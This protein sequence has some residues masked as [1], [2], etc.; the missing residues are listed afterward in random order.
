MPSKRWEERD[1]V[2]KTVLWLKEK[3][4][5]RPEI[6]NKSHFRGQETFSKAEVQIW[7]KDKNENWKKNRDQILALE[8]HVKR[9][10]LH[11][12]SNGEMEI[13]IVHD[14]ITRF[15]QKLPF[16]NENKKYNR[17]LKF[18][19]IK[20]IYLSTICLYNKYI[21]YTLIIL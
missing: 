10:G 2:E 6:N 12:K 13:N 1:R 7:I 20:Y 15:Y 11:T 21:F 8:R 4:V 9:F 14:I 16:Q 5:H 19:A 17:Q 18:K 3:W